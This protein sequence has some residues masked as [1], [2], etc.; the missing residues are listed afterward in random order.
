MGQI[1]FRTK[2][3]ALR[4]SILGYQEILDKSINQ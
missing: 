2:F 1:E 3:Q 4:F